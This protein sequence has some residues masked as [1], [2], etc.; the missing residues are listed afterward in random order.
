MLLSAVLGISV[1][2]IP[3]LAATAQTYSVD[4][5]GTTTFYNVDRLGENECI[6]QEFIDRNGNM[7]TVSIQRIPA[8]AEST[9]T[10]LISLDSLTIDAEYYIDVTN[11]R[12]VD[13]RDWAVYTIGGTY[14]DVELTYDSTHSRLSFVVDISDFHSGSCWLQATIRGTNNEV[15]VTH[16]V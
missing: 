1:T 13:A 10:W 3:A 16:F 6:T 11:N 5:N 7:A 9:T 15:D 2:Y 4:K 12:I 14:R 8:S